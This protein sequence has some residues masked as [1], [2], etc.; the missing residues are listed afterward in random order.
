MGIF[1]RGKENG[2]AFS[3]LFDAQSK[4]QIVRDRIKALDEAHDE[5]RKVIGFLHG[6]ADRLHADADEIHTGFDAV[7]T[8]L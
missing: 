4:E 1:G 8:R 5:K 7:L 6:E 2:S 3:R